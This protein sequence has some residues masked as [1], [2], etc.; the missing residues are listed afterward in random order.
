MAVNENTN[1]TNIRKT[2]YVGFRGMLK[3]GIFVQKSVIGNMK[4]TMEKHI[5]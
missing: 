1:V 2:F 5:R 3:N 4:K